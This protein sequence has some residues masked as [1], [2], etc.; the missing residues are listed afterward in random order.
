MTSDAATPSEAAV[1]LSGRVRRMKPSSTLALN[2]RVRALRAEG[3]DVIGFGVGE[4]DFGTPSEIV[5]VAVDALRGGRTRYEPVPGPPSTRAAIAEEFAASSGVPCD[6]ADVVVTVGGKSAIYFTLMALVDPGVRDEVVVP[7]PAW[8]SYAPMIELTGGRMV[9]VPA[10]GEHDFRIT[11]E[12]LESA[13]TDRTTA[14]LIN[15]PSNPCGT[16]YP[17][18]ELEAIAEVLQRHPHVAVISDELYRR[19]V[20]GTVEHRMFASL[21]GMAERTITVDGM[22][23]TFAMTGWRL[24]WIVSS[25]PGIAAGIARLQGQVTSHATAFCLPAIDAALGGAGAED[26]AEMRETFAARA[27]RMHGALVAIPGV[28]CPKPTGAFYCFPDVSAAFG[29][30]SAGGTR[31]GGVGAFAEALL[32]EHGVAVVP[33]DAFGE[34]GAGHVRLSFACDE[35]T[36]DEGIRRIAAFFGGL[37]D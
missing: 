4:P 23:K 2:A 32:E 3:R 14:L 31:L 13:I 36:I 22:S 5:D 15:S 19:L 7:T 30:T 17:P 1:R 21:P 37:S 27:E 24:G 29:R 20:Y 10:S 16:M 35:A 25:A 6:P 28:T 33:G 18:A 8:V 26:V 12:Q 34:A 11:P 9:E